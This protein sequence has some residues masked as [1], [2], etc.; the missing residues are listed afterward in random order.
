VTAARRP[1]WY[2]PPPSRPPRAAPRFSADE[3]EKDLPHLPPEFRAADVAEWFGCDAHRAGMLI[4]VLERRGVVR[5]LRSERATG[6]AG[7][8]R[9]VYCAARADFEASRHKLAARLERMD[10]ISTRIVPPPAASGKGAQADSVVARV[11][12][13]TEA[14]I[15]RWLRGSALADAADAI[16]RGAHR[17]GE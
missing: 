17:E 4:A 3:L 10:A 2:R 12:R 15:V 9:H 5:F 6:R 7:A 8:P 16:E 13:E 11:R 14:Q 1:C